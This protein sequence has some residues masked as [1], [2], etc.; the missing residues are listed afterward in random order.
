MACM[1]NDPI[2]NK[3]LLY[4]QLC[5]SIISLLRARLI[6]RLM[7]PSDFRIRSVSVHAPKQQDT[8]KLRKVADVHYSDC[9]LLGC[10]SV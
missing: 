5:Q 10:N 2:V 3:Q 6:A 4:S 7:D 8:Y 1:L 9:G